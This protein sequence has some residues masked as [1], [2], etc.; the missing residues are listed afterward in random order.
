[1]SSSP[2]LFN[3]NLIF[4]LSFS[5]AAR[6]CEG[7]IHSV[8]NRM[9]LILFAPSGLVPINYYLRISTGCCTI[10]YA[11][12]ALYPL[13]PRRFQMKP[14]FAFLIASFPRLMSEPHHTHPSHHLDALLK[15]SSRPPTPPPPTSAQSIRLPPRRPL[16]HPL[17]GAASKALCLPPHFFFSFL[18]T[19]PATASLTP[20]Q[21]GVA[22]NGVCTIGKVGGE[23]PTGDIA[24]FQ[25]VECGRC[26]AFAS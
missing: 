19:L 25:I 26:I 16:L 5:A 15:S 20:L 3:I 11:C 7:R 18:V 4:R 14:L 21:L 1:M 22:F 10:A 24:A 23:P 13:L 2:S 12:I 9:P 8:R 6:N 17:V